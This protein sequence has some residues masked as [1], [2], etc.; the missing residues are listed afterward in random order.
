M[1]LENMKCNLKIEKMCRGNAHGTLVFLAFAQI[2][3][4]VTSRSFGALHSISP[5]SISLLSI[6]RVAMALPRASPVAPAFRPVC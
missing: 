4:A 3:S 1:I 6:C 5:H 2:E